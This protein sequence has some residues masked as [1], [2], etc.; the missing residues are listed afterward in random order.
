MDAVAPGFRA[1]VD[2]RHADAR[3]RRIEDLVFARDADRHGIDQA[4]AVV[5]CVETHGAAD[6]R[7]AERIAVTADAGDY[8]RYQVPCLGMGRRPKRQA[9]Q[10]CYR[11]RTH[12]EPVAQ[13]A[14]DPG[15]RALVGLDIACMIVPL[16]LHHAGEA[17]T[18]VDDARVLA[19]PLDHPW[20]LGG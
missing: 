9:V 17:I 14:A 15:R 20:A 5:A 1:E 7:H 6:R 13:N 12:P 8:T 18:D 19:R 11:P 2:D 10:A 4:I 16:H 3:S